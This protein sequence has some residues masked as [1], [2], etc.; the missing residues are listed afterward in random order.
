[1]EK[2]IQCNVASIS[3]EVLLTAYKQ[4]V[5]WE[6]ENM[7]HNVCRKSF[8]TYTVFIKNIPRIERSYVFENNIM[9][10]HLYKHMG[11]HFY[12]LLQLE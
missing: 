1:M 4:Q 6:C 11:D 7:I 5:C 3:D 12:H 8:C 9:Y 2:V 10:V